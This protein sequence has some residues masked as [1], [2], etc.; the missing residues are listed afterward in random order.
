MNG[1]AVRLVLTQRQMHFGNGLLIQQMLYLQ[2]AG[3]T[4]INIV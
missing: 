2:E 4:F 1:F 3:H